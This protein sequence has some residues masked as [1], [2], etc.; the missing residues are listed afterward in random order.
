MEVTGHVEGLGFGFESGEEPVLFVDHLS[1]L[2]E[3]L[4]PLKIKVVL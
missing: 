1:F 4:E 3:S 2:K